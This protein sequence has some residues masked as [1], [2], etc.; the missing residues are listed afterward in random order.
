MTLNST[1]IP[2]PGLADAERALDAINARPMMTRWRATHWLELRAAANASGPADFLVEQPIAPAGPTRLV[3]GPARAGPPCLARGRTHALEL[4]AEQAGTPPLALL[5]GP[6]FTRSEVYGIL[7]RSG[8]RIRV[9][10]H[11]EIRDGEAAPVAVELALLSGPRAVLESLVQRLERAR[12][13]PPM[14][15]DAATHPP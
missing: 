14:A 11:V 5:R 7:V 6:E 3:P 12:P 15:N 13:G 10:M 8:A 9:A 2:T 4:A 1:R